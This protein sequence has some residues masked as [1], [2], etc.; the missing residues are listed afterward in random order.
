MEFD[1]LSLKN[2]SVCRIVN[3]FCIAKAIHIA[4]HLQFPTIQTIH[5]YLRYNLLICIE[6]L[7]NRIESCDSYRKSYDFDYTAND[8][9]YLSQRLKYLQV[10]QTQ[11]V[12]D[13]ISMQQW[14]QGC[15]RWTI[16]KSSLIGY[17]VSPSF[18]KE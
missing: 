13:T 5:T 14:L 7:M 17:I 15:W 10:L 2:V 18:T 8:Y 1:F 9:A 6:K 16:M 11:R 4:I 3:R 12:P